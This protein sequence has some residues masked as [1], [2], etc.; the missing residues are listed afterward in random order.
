MVIFSKEI[1]EEHGPA[2]MPEKAIEFAMNEFAG[3]DNCKYYDRVMSG[4][5]KGLSLTGCVY[6]FVL[7]PEGKSIQFSYIPSSK[8]LKVVLK[9]ENRGLVP[10]INAIRMDDF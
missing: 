8:D 10:I 2:D 1:L 3:L 9:E 6:V 5:Q 7:C 4:V